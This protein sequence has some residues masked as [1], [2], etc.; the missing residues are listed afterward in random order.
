MRIAFALWGVIFGY[1][2]MPKTFT[3]DFFYTDKGYVERTYKYIFKQLHGIDLDDEAFAQV[4]QKEPT[5]FEK[6][7]SFFGF[8]TDKDS[9]PQNTTMLNESTTTIADQQVPPILANWFN[10]D[11]FIQLSAPAQMYAKTAVLNCYIGSID[12]MF[13]EEIQKIEFPKERRKP[14][15]NKTEWKKCISSFKKML[16]PKSHKKSAP[17]KTIDHSGELF[18]FYTFYND[19]NAWEYI[20][21]LIPINLQKD[22]KRDIE[23]FQN[24]LAKGASSQWYHHLE[25]RENYKVIDA[26]IRHLGNKFGDKF[27][28][29][30]IERALKSYYPN[31]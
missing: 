12:D 5:V 15:C 4:E 27:N 31:E 20:K 10:S 19:A 6:M 26:Y 1:A 13:I 3:N 14:L 7:R 2:E 9:E 8:G 11:A 25:T 18:P 29:A 22:I 23:W 16:S 30:E 17:R 21:H 24:E 28:V